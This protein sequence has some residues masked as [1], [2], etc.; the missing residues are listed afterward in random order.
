PKHSSM[1]WSLG[2][3]PYWNRLSWNSA[4]TWRHLLCSRISG[5]ASNTTRRVAVAAGAVNATKVERAALVAV[6]DTVI[7]SVP[8]PV[9]VLETVV[10]RKL[11]ATNPVTNRVLYLLWGTRMLWRIVV[12][13]ER[14]L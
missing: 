7:S 4:S 1:R 14:L 13:T 8:T 9:D 2:P 3:E 12:A 10:R 11:R 6:P 5:P